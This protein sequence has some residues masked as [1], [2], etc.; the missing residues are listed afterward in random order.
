[1]KKSLCLFLCLLSLSTILISCAKICSHEYSNGVCTKCNE[2]CSHT[3]ENG[4][5]TNC[6][7]VCAHTFENAVCSIC[8][9]VCTHAFENAVCS[10]CNHVCTHAFENGVC[11][12]CKSKCSHTF[13]KGMCD[14]CGMV[15]LSKSDLW[16]RIFEYAYFELDWAENATEKDKEN[17][18]KNFYAENDDQLFDKL[19]TQYMSLMTTFGSFFVDG[20]KFGTSTVQISKGGKFSNESCQYSIKENTIVINNETFYYEKDKIYSLGNSEDFKGIRIKLVFSEAD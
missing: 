7:K 17:L 1:M 19:H 15:S 18:R 9:H 5:C 6:E 20:Y 16:E 13:E 2:T 4:I 11:S 3:F 14:N 10:I 12:V 8:N